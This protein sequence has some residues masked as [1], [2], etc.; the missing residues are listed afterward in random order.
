MRWD[1]TARG[2]PNIGRWWHATGLV[3]CGVRPCHYLHERLVAIHINRHRRCGRDDL[4]LDLVLLDRHAA[5]DADRTATWVSERFDG[6]IRGKRAHQ[7]ET[8]DVLR[9]RRCHRESGTGDASDRRWAVNLGRT[10][11]CPPG[12]PSYLGALAE[13]SRGVVV[14]RRG[15]GLGLTHGLCL[16]LIY[17]I[18]SRCPPHVFVMK[19]T[20]ARH[21]HY[22]ALGRP[23]HNPRLWCVLGRGW[24]RRSRR[25]SSKSWCRAAC[26]T[27]WCEASRPGDSSFT[28]DE[29]R[30][31][32]I[33]LPILP[34]GRGA[35]GRSDRHRSP[36]RIRPRWVQPRRHRLRID[37]PAIV[38]GALRG[39]LPAV[40][41]S[42]IFWSRGARDSTI[43][44]DSNAI[45]RTPHQTLES[46]RP[47][48][49]Q[50]LRLRCLFCGV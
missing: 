29:S 28:A 13:T 37:R 10:S 33:R 12:P 1:T 15:D 7:P 6:G 32:H 4:V 49:R 48:R 26:A 50:P 34:R 43:A 45:W 47:V 35:C 27:Q 30:T 31:A 18:G 20:H 42:R 14:E 3:V 17:P 11:L 44:T 38:L 16:R 25:F 39:R 41:L 5:D 22:P 40:S 19:S 9:A 21:C 36:F 8:D 24:G 2:A 23:L 46:R